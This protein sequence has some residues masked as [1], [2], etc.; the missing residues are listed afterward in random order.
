M[1][2]NFGA[3]PDAQPAAATGFSFGEQS[4]S[5]P[6]APTF[7]FGNLDFSNPAADDDDDEDEEYEEEEDEEEDNWLFTVGEPMTVDDIRANFGLEDEAVVMKLKANW[8][9]SLGG[10]D[11]FFAA[12]LSPMH[13]YNPLYTA[14]LP[15]NTH[16]TA[17]IHYTAPTYAHYTD[18]DSTRKELTEAPCLIILD[19]SSFCSFLP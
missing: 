2:F 17:S 11:S 1:A 4:P 19:C 5:A 18:L 9:R 7:S 3:Q 12:L 6:G 8:V 15:L 13:P 10:T 16:H 14:T